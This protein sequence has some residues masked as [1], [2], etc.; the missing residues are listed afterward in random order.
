MTKSISNTLTRWHK[1]AER[2]KLAANELMEKN[3][4]SVQAGHGLD[5]DTFAVRKDKLLAQTGTTIGEQTSLY[6]TLQDALFSIRRAL[7]QANVQHGV[8]DFLNQMEQAKQ[9]VN[10]YSSLVDSAAGALS[11]AEYSALCSKRNSNSNSSA[12]YGV[13]VTFLTEVQLAELTEKRNAARREVNAFADRLADANATKL[14]LE[15]SA[16]VANVVGI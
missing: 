8:A 6:F 3:L 9:K 12:M 4:M 10:Y 16:E 7:A 1:I 15:I 5:V 14:S 2:V 11:V 13:T